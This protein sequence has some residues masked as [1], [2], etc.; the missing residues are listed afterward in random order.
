MKSDFSRV[1]F[2]P[3][4]QF[5]AVLH[6][7]G[8]ALTDADINEQA[9]IHAH[10]YESL[11][12]SLTGSEGA[13]WLAPAANSGQPNIPG[14]PVESRH[15][16]GFR[17]V[18]FQDPRLTKLR[19]ALKT[20]AEKEAFDKKVE[21]FGSARWWI[22]PG[23]YYAGGLRCENEAWVPVG[24][25][26]FL[27]DTLAKAQVPSDKKENLKRALCFYLDAWERQLSWLDEARLSDIALGTTVDTA[28]RAQIVWQVRSFSIPTRTNAASPSFPWQRTQPRLRVRIKPGAV[29]KDPCRSAL[30]G[31]WQGQENQLYRVEIHN[32]TPKADGKAVATFKWSRE[33]GSV[34]A[35]VTGL[36]GDAVAFSPGQLKAGGFQPRDRVELVKNSDELAGQ[37]GRIFIVTKVHGDSL[38]CEPLTDGTKIADLA[39]AG[40]KLRRWDQRPCTGETIAVAHEWIELEQGIEVLFEPAE[41]QPTNSAEH[42]TGTDFRTGDYWVFTA[43]TANASVDWP[44]EQNVETIPAEFSAQLADIPNAPSFTSAVM[45]VRPG[46]T[47]ASPSTAPAALPPHGVRH[48]YA[49]LAL[50]TSAAKSDWD[51]PTDLRRILSLNVI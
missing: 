51:A 16:P 31:A 42:F 33:N 30:A 26:P 27:P 40:D 46:V 8:R 13:I 44:K 36:K 50:T 6:Q 29:S 39:K 4:S 7:Q 34:A 43:R 12:A 15:L 47:P 3:A 48:R 1:S 28:M 24:A 25:Q 10:F 22:S 9:G 45:A 38:T 2:D 21:K 49:I 23:H 14:I 20:D 19:D 5:T 37:P 32:D 41:G 17:I 11:A 35:R 18:D